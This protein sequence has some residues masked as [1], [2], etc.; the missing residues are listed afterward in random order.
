MKAHTQANFVAAKPMFS[1]A[2]LLDVAR[3]SLTTGVWFAKVGG[4]NRP[5]VKQIVR[6]EGLADL[7]WQRSCFGRSGVCN[8]GVVS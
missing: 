1:R 7:I 2:Q 3:E 6:R 8:V 4:M 5:A